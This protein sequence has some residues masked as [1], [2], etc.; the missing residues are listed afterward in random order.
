MSERPRGIETERGRVLGRDKEVRGQGLDRN[1]RSPNRRHRGTQ[2]TRKGQRETE[3][4]RQAE[5]ERQIHPED[6]ESSG[7]ES[8]PHTLPAK[9]PS[10]RPGWGWGLRAAVPLPLPFQRSPLPHACPRIR[11]EGSQGLPHPQGSHSRSNP[12]PNLGGPREAGKEWG[13]LVAA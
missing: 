4:G 7:D 12:G 11:V 3:T 13:P 2:R 9:R 6:R 1:A 5:R 10:R 8:A